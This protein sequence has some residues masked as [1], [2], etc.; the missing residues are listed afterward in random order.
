MLWTIWLARNEAAFDKGRVIM[1]T[2][3]EL[4]LA[5]VN[6]WGKALML[7]DFGD[8]PLWRVNP[9]G[10]VALHHFKVNKEFSV[11]AWEEL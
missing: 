5:R 7:M 1:R 9:I 10:A 2:L 11:V 6:K 4:I 8:D 3:E